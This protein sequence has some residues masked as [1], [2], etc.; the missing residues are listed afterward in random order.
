MRCHR[1]TPAAPELSRV[2]ASGGSNA[3]RG[4]GAARARS[5]HVA[6]GRKAAPPLP[7]PAGS[8]PP[9]FLLPVPL[10]GARVLWRGPV[11]RRTRRPPPAAAMLVL[12]ETAAG[13]AIFKVSRGAG[14]RRRGA[15]RPE[16]RGRPTCSGAE[17]R[18][19]GSATG[20][21]WELRGNTGGGESE[22][23]SKGRRIP[24]GGRS[25]PGMG[26]GGPRCERGLGEGAAGGG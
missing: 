8:L 26:A 17:G 12:F 3:R 16:G 14:A 13:Y 20:L 22:G 19:K 10:C 21:R 4:R 18:A 6:G 9:P 25:G 7:L 11:R 1:A 2:R 15:S 5:R 23:S 24:C